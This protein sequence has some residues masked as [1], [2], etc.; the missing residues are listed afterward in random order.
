MQFE[1]VL[2]ARPARVNCQECG[3]H[4]ARVPWAQPSGRFTF[5]FE[6]FAIHI[7]QASASLEQARLLL[8]LSWK[9]VQRIID[10]AV[11]R[12]LAKRHG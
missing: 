9:N 6:A 8:R 11:D 3:V 7:I 4:T 10:E 2:T 1:T 5:M 12:G